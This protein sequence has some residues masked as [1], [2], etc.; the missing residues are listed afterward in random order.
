MN[1]VADI[2]IATNSLDLEQLLQIESQ[3]HALQRNK[4]RSVIFDDGFGLWTE[5]D[6]TNAASQAWEV[7]EASEAISLTYKTNARS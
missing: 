3:H 7:F 6:Q 2:T 1:T 4:G 5:E